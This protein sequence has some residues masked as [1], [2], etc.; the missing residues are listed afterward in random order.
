M[1]YSFRE[2]QKVKISQ[3]G[4][5]TI[6]FLTTEIDSISHNLSSKYKPPSSVFLFVC[7]FLCFVLFCFLIFAHSIFKWGVDTI[8]ILLLAQCK[9]MCSSQM[10][11]STVSFVWFCLLLRGAGRVWQCGFIL[12]LAHLSQ[13]SME[14]CIGKN[15]N[16]LVL[17]LFL[18]YPFYVWKCTK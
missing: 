13:E 9:Q 12:I 14:Y 18:S 1:V 8:S 15:H 6:E 16:C 17:P 5:E 4:K 11:G 3:M 7:L 2:S 10:F